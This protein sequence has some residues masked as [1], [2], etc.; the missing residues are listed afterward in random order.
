MGYVI[1]VDIGGTCTDCVIL[2]EA[3]RVTVSKAFSTP[4]DFSGGVVNAVGLGAGQLHLSLPDL[5]RD[6]R[7]FLHATTVAEN[8]IIEGDLAELAF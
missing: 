8:A 3:G 1:G 5:L 6:T 7:L 2:D 4:P